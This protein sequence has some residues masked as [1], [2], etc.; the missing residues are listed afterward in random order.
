VTIV[1][2]SDDPA[3]RGYVTLDEQGVFGSGGNVSR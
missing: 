3:L 2:T 1:V